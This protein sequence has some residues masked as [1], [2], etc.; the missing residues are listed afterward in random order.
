MTQKMSLENPSHEIVFAARPAALG[1]PP[2]GGVMY[3]FTPK[4][5]VPHQ[6]IFCFGLKSLCT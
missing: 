1:T 6:G 4:C 2:S 5:K 3:N